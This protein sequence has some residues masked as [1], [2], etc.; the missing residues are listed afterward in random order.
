MSNSLFNII[1]VGQ[2]GIWRHKT[3]GD[4]FSNWAVLKRWVEADDFPKGLEMAL[5]R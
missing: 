1:P 2:I 4:V 3:P 5:C